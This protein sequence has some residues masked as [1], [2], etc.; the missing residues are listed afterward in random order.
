MIVTDQLIEIGEA[1]GTQTERLRIARKMLE[2]K[3]EAEDVHKFTDITKE[4][5]K[6]LVRELRSQ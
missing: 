2:S 5:L 1:L 6:R 4:E 3:M